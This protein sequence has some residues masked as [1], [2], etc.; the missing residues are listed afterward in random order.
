MINIVGGL[1]FIL[2]TIAITNTSFWYG[3]QHIL[4]F[5]YWG[6]AIMG[7][8]FLKR[9]HVLIESQL[10]ILTIPLIVWAFDFIYYILFGHSLLNIVSYFFEPGPILAKIITSQHLFTIPLALYTIRFIK[11]KSKN[12]LKFSML[13]IF[14]LFILSRLLTNYEHN[15]NWVYHT[16]LNL[17][18]PYYPLFWFGIMFVIIYLTNFLL[19][20]FQLKFKS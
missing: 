5:C 3:P 9:N 15:I 17:G 8:G 18:I 7:I 4:W 19:K 14:I 13:M 11:P 10:N 12:S 20:K 1:F 6:L 16:S 2:G